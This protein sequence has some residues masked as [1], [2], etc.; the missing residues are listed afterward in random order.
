MVSS[1]TL[2]LPP[3]VKTEGSQPNKVIRRSAMWSREPGLNTMS[4]YLRMGTPFT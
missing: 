3:S 1:S 2:G 4:L